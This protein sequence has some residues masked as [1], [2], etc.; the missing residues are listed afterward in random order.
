MS[1]PQSSSSSPESNDQLATHASRGGRPGTLH[2][3][4]RLCA[5]LPGS[6]RPAHRKHALK[7]CPDGIPFNVL[8]KRLQPEH[9]EWHQEKVRKRNALAAAVLSRTAVA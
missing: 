5:P 2:S 8:L 3:G 4:P 1:S 6:R 9:D 7:E